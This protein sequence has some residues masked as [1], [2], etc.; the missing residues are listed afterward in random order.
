MSDSISVARGMMF[1][2]WTGETKLSM[3]EGKGCCFPEELQR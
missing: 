3:I 2:D 1:S